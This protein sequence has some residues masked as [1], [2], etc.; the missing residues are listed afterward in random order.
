MAA[1]GQR[2][3]SGYTTEAA[4]GGLSSTQRSK[5][6]TFLLRFLLARRIFRR[7]RR[8]RGL[9]S[10]CRRLCRHHGCFCGGRRLGGCSL[11]LWSCTAERHK[12]GYVV[13]VQSL[14]DDIL[15]HHPLDS[16]RI[17]LRHTCTN[18]THPPPQT[19]PNLAAGQPSCSALRQARAQVRASSCSCRPSRCYHRCCPHRCSPS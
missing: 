18:V 13:V 17:A 2:E 10:L 16:A 15:L 8:R 12:W 9:C 1:K 14:T 3:I 5:G 11:W 19:N 6:R 7:R 4:R